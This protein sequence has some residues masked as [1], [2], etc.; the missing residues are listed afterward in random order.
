MKRFRDTNYFVDEEG[1]VYRKGNVKKTFISN[2]GYQMVSIWINGKCRNHYIHRIV[3]EV[4][5]PNPNKFPVVNHID[6]NKL[7]N[8]L[9][10]LEWTT[11]QKN[12]HHAIDLGY[13]QAKGEDN[14]S[15]KLKESDVL[16]IRKTFDP[17][18]KNKNATALA[19]KYGV[20]FQQIYRIL[21]RERWKHI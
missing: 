3:A 9:D 2:S 4:Y 20:K 18:D 5:S 19:K 17:N 13:F 12:I 7:N 8:N 1:N 16:E 21:N 10:N 15:S 14:V 11:Y 6:G